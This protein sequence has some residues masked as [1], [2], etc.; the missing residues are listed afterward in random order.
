MQRLFGI[1]LLL[2]LLEVPFVIRTE[3]INNNTTT[4][5]LNTTISSTATPNGTTTLSKHYFY[6]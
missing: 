4:T 2:V 5:H 1:F 3:T 6:I